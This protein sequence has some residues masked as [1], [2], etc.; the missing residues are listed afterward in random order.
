[1]DIFEG[2]VFRA[3]ER[4]S[5]KVL[6]QSGRLETQRRSNAAAQDPRQSAGRI[7]SSLGDVS[8]SSSRPLTDWMRSP[9]SGEESAFYSESTDLN[10]NPI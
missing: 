6:W 9:R 4:V 8:L 2:K 5:T 1:M 7:P 3:E 10:I